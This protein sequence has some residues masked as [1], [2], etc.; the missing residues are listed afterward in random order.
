[1]PE[2]DQHRIERLAYEAGLWRGIATK[3]AVALRTHDGVHGSYY[4]EHR[5][6][7]ALAA[8]DEALKIDGADDV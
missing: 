5:A 4:S 6:R 8:F 3:L 2:T 1:M 7:E